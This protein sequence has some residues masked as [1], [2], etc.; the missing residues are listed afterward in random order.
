M[1]DCNTFAVD[2]LPATIDNN[3]PCPCNETICFSKSNIKLDTGYLDSNEHLGINF[4]PDERVLYRHFYSCATLQTQGNTEDRTGVHRNFTRYH[5]G[6]GGW[7]D[8]TDG[9]PTRLNF[10][11]EELSLETQFYSEVE[12]KWA[13][14]SR[15]AIGSIGYVYLSGF[16][17]TGPGS[18]VLVSEISLY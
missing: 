7:M 13:R 10:T 11:Y 18:C 14:A 6:L 16:L 8:P 17:L 4:P 12:D 2:R 5:Y 15:R 1:F 9:R 3:A